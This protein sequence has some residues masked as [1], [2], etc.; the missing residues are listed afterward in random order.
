MNTWE[1]T[2]TRTLRHQTSTFVPRMETISH[3]YISMDLNH[4]VNEWN[5]FPASVSSLFSISVMHRDTHILIHRHLLKFCWIRRIFQP[6]M[7]KNHTCL[8][9]NDICRVQLSL[10]IPGTQFNLKISSES[11]V[12]PLALE[13]L[14]QAIFDLISVKRLLFWFDRQLIESKHK[15]LTLH[16]ECNRPLVDHDLSEGYLSQLSLDSSLLI[17]WALTIC[18]ML[19]YQTIRQLSSFE[20]RSRR[21]CLL[22][23]SSQPVSVPG[24]RATETETRGDL[25]LWWRER[26]GRE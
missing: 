12:S 16:W 7:R 14:S 2:E 20:K 22:M 4:W 17:T 23:V 19:L 18:K 9:T 26:D 24:Q 5:A 11:S 6:L 25:S 15:Y 21:Q 13:D 8:V 3:P 10:S 1:V